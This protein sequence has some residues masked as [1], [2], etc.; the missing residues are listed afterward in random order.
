[1]SATAPTRRLIVTADDSGRCASI[2]EAVKLAKEN[3]QLG[4]GLHLTLLMGH[5][6]LSA[7]EIPGLVNGRGEFCRQVTRNF[8][9]IRRWTNFNMSSMLSPARA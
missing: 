7:S 5:A 1:M 2:S 8:I 4:A 9:R 6:A 3:P